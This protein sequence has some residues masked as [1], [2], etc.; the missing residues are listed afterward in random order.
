MK[1]RNT[2]TTADSTRR[3]F[4]K[5]SSLGLA[6]ATAAVQL[7]FVHTA[8]VAQARVAGDY[9]YVLARADELAYVSGREREAFQDMVT[10]ALLRAGVRTGISPKAYYKTLTRQ[11]GRKHRV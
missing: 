1:K 2:D 10:T 4:L 5:R 11:G 7:P 6:G 3:Q 8:I 9:P